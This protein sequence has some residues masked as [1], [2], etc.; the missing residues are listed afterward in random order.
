MAQEVLVLLCF[1]PGLVHVF[2]NVGLPEAFVVVVDGGVIAV[3]KV[4][5]G[6]GEDVLG[7][8]LAA[9]TERDLQEVSGL[10]AVSSPALEPWFD[11]SG[12]AERRHREQTERQEI[13]AHGQVQFTALRRNSRQASPRN[14]AA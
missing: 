6:L 2:D 8:Q 14:K 9:I 12:E 3:V 11:H 10:A 1:C 4:G 13:R 5:V 7:E